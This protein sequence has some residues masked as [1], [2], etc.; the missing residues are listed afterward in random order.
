MISVVKAAEMLDF[1]DTPKRMV[2]LAADGHR[3]VKASPE[4]RK[5]IWREQL[6]KLGLFKLVRDAIERQPERQVTREFVLETIVLNLPSENYEKVFDT[7]VGWARFGDL[8]AYD[9]DTERLSL[10]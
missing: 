9:E 7:L 3:L 4:G 10:Q 6:L 1:V 2:V 5:V 8:F